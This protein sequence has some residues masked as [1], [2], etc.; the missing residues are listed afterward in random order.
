MSRRD[1]VVVGASAGGVEALSRFVEAL[2]CDFPAALFVVLHVPAH[3]PS[4]LPEILTSRGPLKAF[5]AEDGEPI[6]RGRIYVAPPDR[7]LLLEKNRVLVK[8]GPKEN[9]FRPSVDALFRS[10]AYV[11]G[12]RAVG[13]VLSGALD[14]GT[15]GLW[16]IKRMNGVAIAQEPTEAAFSDMPANALQHI[17]MDHVVPVAQMG[18]LLAG[19][20]G[21][22]APK[23]PKLSAKEKKRLEME[24]CIAR[25]DCTFERGI[26]DIGELSPFTCPEC[27][28]ALVRLKEG[29]RL[30]FRCHTGHAFTA[31]GLLAGITQGNED[32]LWQAMRSY[33]ESVMLLE[34][35]GKHFKESKQAKSAQRFFKKAQEARDMAQVIHQA[36]L[37]TENL[38]ED[39]QR[40]TKIDG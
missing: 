37:K 32:K 35:L 7:H 23:P 9:R 27:H 5:H 25:H 1:I 17:K 40:K 16:T 20:V 10:A 12:S 8:N 26:M 21:E 13:I 28:G 19:I 14:D 2:P 31:S 29:D 4:R 34:H 15:S 33:E 11:F 6:S 39:L 36:I 38:S 18:T 3:S 24:I 22:I 30:R